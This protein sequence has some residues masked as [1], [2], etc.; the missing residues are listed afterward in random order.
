MHKDSEASNLLYHCC[1]KLS[2][3]LCLK[4]KSNVCHVYYLT[5]FVSVNIDRSWCVAV[6]GK[7]WPGNVLIRLMLCPFNQCSTYSIIS[8]K[9][10]TPSGLPLL[11]RGCE[12]SRLYQK[13]YLLAKRGLWKVYNHCLY[14]SVI[15]IGICL[16][17]LVY[18][19]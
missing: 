6:W 9:W 13:E 17:K 19:E 4:I 11:L 5:R 2:W 12:L 7:T 14:L 15:L 8:P 10:P 1:L 18:S 3:S 16:S